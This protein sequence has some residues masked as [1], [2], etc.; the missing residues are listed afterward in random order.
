M[1][2][3]KVILSTISIALIATML[4]T[5][6]I[7]GTIPVQAKK[8]SGYYCFTSGGQSICGESKKVCNEIRSHISGE[9]EPTK[10]TRVR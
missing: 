3:N 5:M 6:V 9:P 8:T 4:L 10:C 2:T 1:K 7:V